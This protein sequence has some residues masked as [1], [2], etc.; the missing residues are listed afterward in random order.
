MGRKTLLPLILFQCPVS[1]AH[2]SLSPTGT[3]PH[4]LPLCFLWDT[5]SSTHKVS[6]V[7]ATA[8]SCRYFSP[9]AASLPQHQ[10]VMISSQLC[11][12]SSVY[13]LSSKKSMLSFLKSMW[14]LWSHFFLCRLRWLQ[15]VKALLSSS[16]E[17][18]PHFC[19][20]AA[21]FSLFSGTGWFFG[22][23]LWAMLVVRPSLQE[24]G[25]I[26]IKTSFQSCNLWF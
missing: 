10:A 7:Q 19:G 15:K 1:A 20:L 13:L 6:Q 3:P 24:G 9:A 14:N 16:P 26:L 21:V 25:K 18:L 11:S 2:G 4:C 12:D 17:H 22:N 8:Q 23:Y 5:P